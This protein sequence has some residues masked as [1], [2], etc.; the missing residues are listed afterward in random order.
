VTFIDAA[1]SIMAFQMSCMT[2]R[3]YSKL[4]KVQ[5]PTFPIAL[6]M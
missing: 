4:H 6:Y 3:F 2:T 5:F 1:V